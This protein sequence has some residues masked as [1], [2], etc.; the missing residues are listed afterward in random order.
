FAMLVSAPF[1]NWW[2]NAYGLDVQI[3]SPPH[4]VLA[5]G[6]V[7]IVIGALLMTLAEQNR[8][9]ADRHRRGA[10]GLRVHLRALHAVARDGVVRV[11]R[12]SQSLARPDLLS[13][14]G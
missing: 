8:R 1:D 14:G 10:V 6:M 7:A 3:V 9:G 2:H 4:M 11:H 12:L 5:A 13:G